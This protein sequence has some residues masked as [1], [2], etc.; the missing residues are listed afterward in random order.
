MNVLWQWLRE[1]LRV[2]GL[3]I[4]HFAWWL[5]GIGVVLLVLAVSVSFLLYALAR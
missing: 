2:V 4:E 5:I 3:L 1:G